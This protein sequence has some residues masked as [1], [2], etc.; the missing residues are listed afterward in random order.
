MKL[1]AASAFALG[2]GL[3]AITAS[4]AMPASQL[5]QAP[6][7]STDIINVAQGCGRGWHRGPYGHCRRLFRCPRGWHPGP[8]GR[9]CFRNRR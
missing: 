3:M 9:R 2:F 6:A 1:L 8:H 7:V 4:Q 5:G